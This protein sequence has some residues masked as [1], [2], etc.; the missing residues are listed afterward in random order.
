PLEA[1]RLLDAFTQSTN[2]EVGLAVV[3]ALSASPAKA[4]LRVA[5]L[6][7]RLE[8][9]GPAVQREA[10]RL[11]ATLDEDAA[12]QQARLEQMLASL[13][14]GDVRRG[15][16]VFNGQKAV[17]SACHAVGYVGGKVG[18]DLTVIGRVRTERDLLES[19]VFPSASFVRGYEPVT[20]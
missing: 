8:K 5:A 7:P 18:P 10:E 19:I 20:V 15:Q 12:K 4:S 3:A 13:L 2:D 14:P 11:Y 16:A 17:C 1:E 6:R 9:Y